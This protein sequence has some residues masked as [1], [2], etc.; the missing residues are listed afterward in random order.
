MA[1][2]DTTHTT[3]NK[4]WFSTAFRGNLLKLIYLTVVMNSGYRKAGDLS[5]LTNVCAPSPPPPPKYRIETD[6]VTASFGC[7]L[8]SEDSKE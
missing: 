3:C 2:M 8:I 7:F 6:N 1:A 5:H 4:Q